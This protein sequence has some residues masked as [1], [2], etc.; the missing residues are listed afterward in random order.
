MGGSINTTGCGEPQR[1][2]FIAHAGLDGIA[3]TF[4]A[5]G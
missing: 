2:G 1:P 3:P 5:N 4:I